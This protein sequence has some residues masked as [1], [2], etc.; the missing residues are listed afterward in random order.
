MRQMPLALALAP[1][2]DFDSFVAGANRVALDSL[3]ALAPLSAPAA[4]VYLHGPAGSG[5]THLLAALTH[6]LQR[7]GGSSG[8]FDAADPLPWEFDER[9]SLIVIDGAERL[10]PAHQHAAFSLFV[11]GATHGVQM[12]SAGRLP[13]VDLDLREDLRTRFGWG[14]VFGLQVLSESDSRVAL[15]REAG[16]RGLALPDEVLNF[17]LTRHSRELGSLMDML[18][19]LD[20]FGLAEGRILTVPLLKE[21]VAV[22]GL[23][24]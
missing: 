4:P 5:K 2:P 13:P 10:D 23:Q 9:W 7:Q 3:Q 1:A 14:P 8:W 11:E 17:L 24:R 19:R 22:D 18:D 16:R 15:A 20:R 6:R 21:M 12:A